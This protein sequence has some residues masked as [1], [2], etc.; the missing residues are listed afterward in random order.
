M[1]TYRVIRLFTLALFIFLAFVHFSWAR[2]VTLPLTI[3]HQ[4]LRSLVI[5]TAFS[6]PGPSAILAD[7]HNGCWDIKISEPR[8]S[9]E[10]G[11]LRFQ[12]KVYVYA[13]VFAF[14][15]CI[16]PVEWE[17]YLILYQVPKIDN[18]WILSF[19]IVDSA[20]YNK[21]FEPATIA[22]I[23]WN[24]VKTTVYEYLGSITINLAPPVSELKQ[25]IEPLFPT[26]HKPRADR[27]IR[28][29]RP[30]E[31]RTQTDAVQVDV[32]ADVEE[33]YEKDKDR[34]A[35]KK[36]SKTELNRLLAT[37]ETWDAYLVYI[38]TTLTREPLSD[39]DRQVLL[40]V[41][42]EMRYRFISELTDQTLKKDFVR[43]QFVV[44]WKKLAPLFRNHLGDDPSQD[45][46]GYLA[47]FTASDALSAL[48]K[49]G[50]SLGIEISRNGLVRLARMIVE[51]EEDILSYT[52]VV[53]KE[54]REILG[55]G[56]PLAD[57]GTSFSGEELEIGDETSFLNIIIP[58]A[59][60]AGANSNKN[61]KLH[62]I[63]KWVLKDN[64]NINP[65]I[66]RIKSLISEVINENID[67]SVLSSV[68][69]DMYRQIVLATTWQESCF[70]QFKMRKR[71]I[72]Y[73]RSYNKTSVGLM[74]INE[75]VWR[76]I[77]DRN[78]LRWNIRYNCMAGNEILEL[79]FRKYALLRLKKHRL[80]KSIDDKTLSGLVYAMYNGGPGQFKK[81][82]NRQKTEKYY[83]S[84]RLFAEKQAWLSRNEWGNIRIC[85]VGK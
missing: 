82:L 29:I 18:Q 22:G 36:L 20:L 40:D 70:R 34:E 57:S 46:L 27:M 26:E 65:Y 13:G 17:G 47:F 32:L 66:E 10:N 84:D 3:E 56:P 85:L 53:N 67:K 19:D 25:F 44:A 75:R 30:G 4:L 39:E 73:L 23:I 63:M 69:H 78:Q 1:N 58:K 48:D 2:T 79:Y 21:D 71:K 7:E 41:L 16:L 45:L 43:E 50:P 12:T 8:F 51:K 61:K 31:A 77:Y 38:I 81:Y 60:A 15:K 5:K 74:Q 68:Y 24:L 6:D 37:W 54:L 33:I 59:W 49:I 28:S 64:S 9:E 72:T 62:E 42:L 52:V 14:N 55:F 76:G 35:E 11:L 80:Q 83:L